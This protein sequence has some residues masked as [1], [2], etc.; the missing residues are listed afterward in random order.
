ME[1]SKGPRRVGHITPSSNANLEPLTAAM[2]KPL[3]ARISHHFSRIRVR[4][5]KVCAAEARQFDVAAMLE[6]ANLLVDCRPDAIVW[7]GTSGSWLGRAHDEDIC[8]RIEDSFHVSASTS[9]LAYY[10]VYERAGFDRIALA[11]PYTADL[12]AAIAEEYRKQD[13]RV[14]SQSFLSKSTNTEIGEVHPRELR[15]VLREADSDAAQCIS[16]VCTNL[17]ATA[18]VDEMERELGK[19]IIDF[20]R[21]HLLEGLQDGRR[22]AAA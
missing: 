5:L 1:R 19:P 4:E 20:D 22:R 3:A 16:V 17:A 18:L 6:A 2:N 15:Q 7:N 10:E 8:R 13:L 14:V 21:P 9:T 11:V 12:T